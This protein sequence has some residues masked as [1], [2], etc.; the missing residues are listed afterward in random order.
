VAS[1]APLRGSAIR[2]AVKRRSSAHG[3]SGAGLE[4]GAIDGWAGG[5]CSLMSTA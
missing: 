2:A 4:A 1:D 3:S 5:R